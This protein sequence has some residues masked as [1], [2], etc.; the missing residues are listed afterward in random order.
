MSREKTYNLLI[1][2]KPQNMQSTPII[3]NMHYSIT[4]YEPD[5]INWRT[6]IDVLYN[7]ITAKERPT[8]GNRLPRFFVYNYA[9]WKYELDILFTPE[10]KAACGNTLMRAYQYKATSESNAKSN[11]M[12]IFDDIVC[13]K[14]GFV[15]ADDRHPYRLKQYAV[16]AHHLP[17]SH[18]WD[19]GIRFTEEQWQLHTRHTKET[20]AQG[21]SQKY[22]MFK[23]DGNWY[24]PGWARD[25]KTRQDA[26]DIL[27]ANGTPTMIDDYNTYIC[28]K[29][30]KQ[31]IPNRCLECAIDIEPTFYERGSNNTYNLPQ[32]SFLDDCHA[33]DPINH[34]ESPSDDESEEDEPSELNIKEY[35]ADFWRD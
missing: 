7:C 23:Y 17:F 6:W 10:D 11:I 12:N 26:V 33:D 28:T 13:N 35:K 19:G 8:E 30:I 31:Q 15:H 25:D 32:V 20:M 22:G 29:S 4:D 14:K 18:T 1:F 5:D 27:M 34:E 9:K 3:S 24:Y 21:M 2:Q 16:W